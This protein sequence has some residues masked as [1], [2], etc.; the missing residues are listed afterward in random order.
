MTYTIEV[1]R[2]RTNGHWLSLGDYRCSLDVAKMTG[3]DAAVELQRYV[4][5]VSYG[6]RRQFQVHAEFSV[7]GQ[8]LVDAG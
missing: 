8:P 6:D 1:R 2:E 7:S 3:Q 4:R 5:V